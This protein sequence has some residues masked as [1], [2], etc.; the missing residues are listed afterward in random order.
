M[1]FEHQRHFGYLYFVLFCDDWEMQTSESWLFQFE[2]WTGRKTSP[3]QEQLSAGVRRCRPAMP[4]IGTTSAYLASDL[5]GA[6]ILPFTI[7]PPQLGDLQEASVSPRPCLQHVTKPH[8][9]TLLRLSVDD[10][11]PLWKGG[12]AHQA[13]DLMPCIVKSVRVFLL[14]E[15]CFL[16]CFFLILFWP[17]LSLSFHVDQIFERADDG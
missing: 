17:F 11:L 4:S 9:G 13:F 8:S 16:F 1:T 12:P 10:L 5:P 2:K 6:S 3:G 14:R 15:G 7:S